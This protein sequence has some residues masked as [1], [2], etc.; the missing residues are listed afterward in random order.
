MIVTI[1]LL[2][3][4]LAVVVVVVCSRRRR[5]YDG[6]VSLIHTTIYINRTN[7]IVEHAIITFHFQSQLKIQL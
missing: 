7:C 3:L 5:S 6:D 4:L 2:L 1:L